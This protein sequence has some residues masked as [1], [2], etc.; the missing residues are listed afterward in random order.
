[1]NKTN[2]TRKYEEEEVPTQRTEGIQ[3]PSD[4][5]II[6]LQKGSEDDVWI[7]GQEF[8]IG[9]YKDFVP[10]KT[11]NTQERI[12]TI[13]T[14]NGIILCGGKTV[15]IYNE[16]SNLLGK[17]KGHERPVNAL[18]LKHNI[19]ISGSGDWSLRLWDLNTLTEIDRNVIN[20]N[21]I[22]CLKMIPDEPLV[23]QTSEDL[24]LRI[25]DL[26][27]RKIMKSS[28]ISVGDNFATC[29]DVKGDYIITGH[30]GFDSQGCEAKLWDRRKNQELKAFKGHEQA[31]ESV[32]FI[33]ETVFSCGKDGKINQYSMDG[34]IL[35]TWT[36]PLAKPLVSMEVYKKGLIVANID[37]KV[38][39][40]TVNPIFHA[41]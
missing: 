20:W 11:W 35:D 22:T 7:L 13:S 14:N 9:L 3:L 30:R 33:G 16:D 24:R 31:V 28:V 37:P 23:V 17:L 29:C 36:H 32:K 8:I 4:D 1:M 41:Y 10:Q 21:V 38:M 39:Y 2:D 19:A 5:F 25:W 12:K 27:E 18:A 26:R 34:S 6:G 15:E 40:F